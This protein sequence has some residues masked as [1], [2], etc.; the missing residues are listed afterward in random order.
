MIIH[1]SLYLKPKGNNMNNCKICGQSTNKIFQA[2][3]LYKYNVDYFQCPNCRFGQTEAPHWLEEAYQSSMNISDTGVMH[4]SY[5]MSKVVTSL[6]F[7]VFGS[8]GKYLDYAGGY[9]AFTRRM[10]D[11]GFDFY[12]NDPY[13]QNVMAR[14]FEGELDQKYDAVTTFESF[15]HFENP[16]V[17]IDKILALTDTIILTTDTFPHNAPA[18]KDWWYYGSEHGQHLAFYAKKTFE[19]IASSRGLYYFNTRNVH[20]L[21]KKKPGVL[22]QLFFRLPFKKH[23]L[24]FGYYLAK[25]FLKS[26]SMSDMN[27]FYH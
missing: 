17:E 16:L 14:G 20:V 10:R 11:V 12:W 5:V 27:S 3:V 15:E 2:T 22:S 19:Y 1:K 4:R 24:Y 26:K 13:T 25:P 8:K 23:L 18:H 21:T 9:G 6:L 7:F